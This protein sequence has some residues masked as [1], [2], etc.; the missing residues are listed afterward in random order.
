MKIRSVECPCRPDTSAPVNP[1]FSRVYDQ[2]VEGK[3][4]LT[5]AWSGWRVRG[6]GKLVGPGGAKFNPAQLSMLWKLRRDLLDAIITD[7]FDGPTVLKQLDALRY[8]IGDAAND[9]GTEL[10]IE[11]PQTFFA[12]F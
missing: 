8:A 3:F 2:L 7:A 9:D 1:C 4:E 5:G 6:D 12:G 10:A 11:S